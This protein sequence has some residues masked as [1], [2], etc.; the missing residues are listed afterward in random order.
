MR[1]AVG[2]D[3]GGYPLREVVME[4]INTLGHEVIDFG[5]S[6]AQSC[7]YADYAR[8]VAVAVREGRADLGVLMCGTG[9][10]M[11]IAA[12]KVK[13]VY[14]ALCHDTYSAQM[15]RNHNAAN[16]I[17]MGGRVIDPRLA[18]EILT[19]FLQTE[20]SPEARHQRRRGKVTELETMFATGREGEQ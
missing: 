13:G 20:P 7:D 9:I 16:I 12:N 19:V 15:A 3:H 2:N 10:G 11:A 1:I 5:T 14:A 6:E 18:E 8:Q 17:T 4:V